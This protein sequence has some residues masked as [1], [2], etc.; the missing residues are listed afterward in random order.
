MYSG[1]RLSSLNALLSNLAYARSLPLAP[2]ETSRSAASSRAS[3]RRSSSAPAHGAGASLIAVPCR[4]SAL[5]SATFEGVDFERSSGV[6]GQRHELGSLFVALDEAAGAPTIALKRTA[7]ADTEPHDARPYL[8]ESRWRV[9]HLQ[10]ESRGVRFVT[11][12]YGRG[13]SRWQWPHGRRAI[14]TWTSESGRSGRL[15]AEKDASGI[16]SI[17]LPQLTA[18]RVV[19]TVR[20]ADEA[21]RAE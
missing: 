18:E 4:P 10:L 13:D 20:G 7:R 16:L 12:G 9:H 17:Q 21:R 15:E 14:V 6:I 2:I 5:T 1:E 3:S 8:V 11:Q 19:V